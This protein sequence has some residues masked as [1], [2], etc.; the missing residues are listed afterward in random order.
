MASTPDV[1]ILEVDRLLVTVGSDRG[2]GVLSFTLAPSNVV[3]LTGPSGSGKTTLLKSLARL[4]AHH[5]GEIRFRGLT[6]EDLPAAQ[7][8][9]QVLYVHQKAVMF[10]GTVRS[11]LSRAFTLSLRHRQEPVIAEARDYLSRLM[12][13]DDIIERDALV[14]S[15]G[16]A[17]RVALVRALMVRPQILLL[18]EPTASLDPESREATAELLKEWLASN[19]RGIVAVSHDDVLRTRLPGD[20]VRVAR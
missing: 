11:N 16:E 4:I 20:E 7:W 8:R 10:P 2:P 1:P 18:D 3:W 15:V 13:P 19:E 6:R 14:L 9:S 12:L 5:S 17:A